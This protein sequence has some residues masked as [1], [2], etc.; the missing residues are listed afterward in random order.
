MDETSANVPNGNNNWYILSFCNP[1]S[2]SSSA[3]VTQ[4]ATV[5]DNRNLNTIFIRHKF[6]SG[7]TTWKEL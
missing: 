4:I 5:G 2:V 6:I 7:W 3:Y 1:N